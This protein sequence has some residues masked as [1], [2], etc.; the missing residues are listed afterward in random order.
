V[1]GKG[2]VLDESEYHALIQKDPAVVDLLQHVQG[3]W[4]NRD[5]YRVIPYTNVKPKPGQVRSRLL[6]SETAYNA[7]GQRGLR[8]HPEEPNP[9]P[10]AAVAVKARM[11]GVVLVRRS[12][13]E[14]LTRLVRLKRLIEVYAP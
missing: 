5:F 9:L 2:Q 3:S 1:E 13:A 14:I 10:V 6:F 11:R 7:F 4:R 12:P 8:A